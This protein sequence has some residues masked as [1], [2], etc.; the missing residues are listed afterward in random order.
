MADGEHFVM[1]QGA[2]ELI[3]VSNRESVR[4]GRMEVR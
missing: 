2:D 4:R 3:V 1:R